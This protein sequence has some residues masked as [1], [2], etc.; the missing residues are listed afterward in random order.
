EA[1]EASSETAACRQ[2]ETAFTATIF[3]EYRDNAETPKLPSRG[4]SGASHRKRPSYSDRQAAA[5]AAAVMVT[6]PSHDDEDGDDE[7]DRRS[8]GG[9]VVARFRGGWRSRRVKSL[10]W[11]AGDRSGGHEARMHNRRSESK[12]GRGKARHRFS[13]NQLN[14]LDCGRMELA[15]EAESNV[16]SQDLV[17]QN[18]QTKVRNGGQRSAWNFLAEAVKLLP[19]C[20]ELPAGTNPYWAFHRA[21]HQRHRQHV[22]DSAAPVAAAAVAS[23]ATAASRALCQPPPRCTRPAFATAHKPQP[24]AHSR[25]LRPRWPL[26]PP[27]GSFPSSQAAHTSDTRNIADEPT[28]RQHRLRCLPP[29]SPDT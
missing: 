20:S 1:S 8:A 27:S 18:R 17:T 15:A 21:P 16:S 10:Q 9:E 25:Y 6:R 19:R 23:A 11:H 5:A 12:E 4:R 14:E 28:R 3:S 29:T 24:T 7:E 13:D 26:I 2:L 22:H